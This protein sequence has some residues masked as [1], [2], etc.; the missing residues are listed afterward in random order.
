[1]KEI[2][3][4]KIRSNQFGIVITLALAIILNIPWLIAIVWLVQVLTRLLGSG[5]NVFVIL[6]EPILAPMY[7]NKGSE[8]VE[9]QKFNLSLGIVFLSVSLICLSLQQE[10]LAY[11]FAGLMGLAALSAILGYCIGCTL[12]YQ[13][14]RLKAK[15]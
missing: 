4:V 11:L 13:Y 2:P 12:Y 10:I 8:A 7:K 15:Q 1:L 6:L 9:L 3:I 14:K 5:A